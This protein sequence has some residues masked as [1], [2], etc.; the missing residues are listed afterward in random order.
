MT[1]EVVELLNS[2]VPFARHAGVEVTSV[3]PDAGVAILHAGP[4]SLNHIGSVHAGLIFTLAETAAGAAMVGV[5]SDY[6][7]TAVPVAASA[8]ISYVAVAHGDLTATGTVSAPAAEL[9][10]ELAAAGKVRFAVAVDIADATGV[11]VA[12]C[13]VDWHVRLRGDT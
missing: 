8:Q 7:A 5:F 3:A 12:T 9:L 13:V 10:E 6:I 2:A 11:T 4:D 1:P